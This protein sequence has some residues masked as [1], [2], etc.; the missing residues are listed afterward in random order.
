[1]PKLGMSEIRRPQLIRATMR[2]IHEVGLPNA[3]VAMIGRKAG[4]SPSIINHYFGGKSG[5][6]EATMR[7][8]LKDLS[9]AVVSR[10][11]K[12]DKGDIAGRIEAIVGGNFDH[13]QV[14]P[15]VVKTWLAFWAQAMHD[16]ALFRLQRVNEQRLLSHLRIELKRV[17]PE[18][19]ALFLA[20]TIAALIDGI[21]LRGALNPQGINSQ[22][23]QQTIQDYLISKNIIHLAK[24]RQSEQKA[25][26]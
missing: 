10:L 6:L 22:L 19:E 25:G 7:S 4:I 14:D 15:M 26:H 12:V 8:V 5:L 2:V 17:V 1:M 16:K 18:H 24:Q 21:W 13:K 9:I 20:T 3:T 11:Q 23:A